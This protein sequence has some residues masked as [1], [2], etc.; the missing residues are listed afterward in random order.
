[1]RKWG[2]GHRPVWYYGEAE[3]AARDDLR[4]K[5]LRGLKFGMNIERDV[6]K[7]NKIQTQGIR[8]HFWCEMKHRELCANGKIKIV[9][10][11]DNFVNW[12][13]R[14]MTFWA[15]GLELLCP[16][17]AL[18]LAWWWDKGNLAPILEDLLDRQD[19]EYWTNV[20]PDRLGPHM[21]TLTIWI[22]IA[23]RKVEWVRGKRDCSRPIKKMIKAETV[24]CIIAGL[25]SPGVCCCEMC[26]CDCCVCWE[27]AQWDKIELTP[28][29]MLQMPAWVTELGEEPFPWREGM[30]VRLVARRR[31]LDEVLERS[32]WGE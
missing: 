26:E 20:Q 27:A 22:K 28:E 24:E 3:I 29:E 6:G 16:R 31:K 12:A 23:R 4:V 15:E 30:Q 32:G 11:M 18:A 13:L 7:R 8:T 9:H 14:K 10:N 1:M 2:G 21:E 17:R 25:D 19:H 5:F